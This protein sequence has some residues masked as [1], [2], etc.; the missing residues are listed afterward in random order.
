[1]RV[2]GACLRRSLSVSRVMTSI[3]T[4]TLV[5]GYKLPCRCHR[6]ASQD[7]QRRRFGREEPSSYCRR[8]SAGTRAHSSR[9]WHSD[10]SP[11]RSCRK[12]NNMGNGANLL[13]RSGWNLPSAGPH[14]LGAELSA[15]GTADVQL[16]LPASRWQSAAARL[17]PAPEPPTATRPQ[18]GSDTSPPC[19]RFAVPGG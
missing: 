3:F 9:S 12:Q 18:T 10:A 16:L 13:V 8:S 11:L 4:T 7:T 17:A 14:R 15:V 1:M 2:G 19:S 5:E 6:D